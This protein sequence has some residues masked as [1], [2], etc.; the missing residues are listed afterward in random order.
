MCL[1][2]FVTF[3]RYNPGMKI[4]TALVRWW[5]ETIAILILL[6]AFAALAIWGPDL[7]SRLR[8]L[9][10]DVPASGGEWERNTLEKSRPRSTYPQDYAE[11][12]V[13]SRSL[14]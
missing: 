8:P 4:N 14:S 6:L 12:S 1:V 10:P 2:L 3:S 7:T 5:T 13:E 11:L 9:P